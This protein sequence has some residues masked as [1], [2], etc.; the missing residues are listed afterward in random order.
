MSSL[1]VIEQA[2]KAYAD[3]RGLLILKIE[4]LNT[5]IEELK[6]KHLGEIKALAGETANAKGHLEAII[7]SSR[8]L[9]VKPRSIVIAGIKVG[10]KK[11]SGKI[12][13]A[14]EELVIKRIKK[15]F[16]KEDEREIY[17]KVTEK[18][19]KKP[20]EDLDAATLKKLGVTLE[21]TDDVVLIKATDSDVDKLI[22]AILKESGG[23]SEELQEAA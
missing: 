15:M 20:L 12:E 18:L 8:S 13:F 6:R 21:G 4:L 9:F 22:G 1:A 23:D 2:T 19:R 5:E 7:D 11:G 16:P 10:L 3:K 14:D 17:I